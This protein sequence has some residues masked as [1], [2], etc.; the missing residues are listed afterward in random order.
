MDSPTRLWAML[1]AAV[2]FVLL[3]ASAAGAGLSGRQSTAAHTDR[4]TEALYSEVQ[5]LSYNLADANAAAATSLLI[6]PVTPSAFTSR[7]GSDITQVEDLLS[8]ASQRVTG[9]AAASH[10][11]Q[12]LAE[13]VPEYT[14]WIGQALANNRFGYPV[15]G[16][17]L[18]QA[19]TMLTTEMLPEVQNV[20]DEQQQATDDGMSSASSADWAAVALCVLALIVLSIAGTK[21]TRSTKRRMNPGVLAAKLAMVALLGWMIAAYGGSSQA[22]HHARGD[23]E[24]VMQAQ[25][26]GSQLALSETYVALQQIDRGEDGG[27]DQQHAQ[28]ALGALGGVGNGFLA[29][30][31]DSAAAKSV[32]P[33]FVSLATCAQN[34][35]KQAAAGDYQ[36]AIAT[37]VGSGQ[38]VG[39]GGCEPGAARLRADLV[40]LTKLNQQRYDADMADVSSSYAGGGALALPLALGLL[41]ALAA[42]WGINRRLAEFR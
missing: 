41:G 2:L 19:S 22:V 13:Q 25:S 3:A 1:L 26:D 32:E 20:I 6:G 27:T 12:L 38:Q 16:A 29:E 24:L 23:F 42:A 8:A 33:D 15:A 9:D 11:L 5:D 40:A 17:Y 28:N 4:A 7:F 39:Q 34:A 21:I 10:Q 36:T 37:T 18:R 35:I 31:S 14:Q 30:Q